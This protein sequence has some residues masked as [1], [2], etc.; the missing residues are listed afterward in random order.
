MITAS[1]S[2]LALIIVIMA[3]FSYVNLFNKN[4]KKI[5]EFISCFILLCMLSFGVIYLI[6]IGNAND[7]KFQRMTIEGVKTYNDKLFVFN[8]EDNIIGKEATIDSMGIDYIW[9]NRISL[10][11]AMSLSSSVQPITENPKVRKLTY[12]VEIEIDPHYYFDGVK[13][14]EEQSNKRNEAAR[15]IKYWLYEFNNENSRKLARFY[16]PLDQWQASQLSIMLRNYLN[17]PQR[18]GKYFKVAKV[19]SFEVI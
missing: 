19:M 17:K 7:I 15:K 12:T 18:L 5:Q 2:I 10:P 16:N 11:L 4:G 14:E 1:V 9:K 6:V 3:T 8:K 13:D